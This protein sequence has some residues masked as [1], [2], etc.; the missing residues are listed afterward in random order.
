MWEHINKRKTLR[1]GIGNE[2][3]ITC[4]RIADYVREGTVD[5]IDKAICIAV[6]VGIDDDT[7]DRLAKLREA[8][9]EVDDLE[10]L[11]TR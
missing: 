3:A 8:R 7:I 6:H 1:D 4:V 11:F 9:R 5:Y 10:K 2:E